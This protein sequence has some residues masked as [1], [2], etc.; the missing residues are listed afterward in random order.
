[1]V[2]KITRMPEALIAEIQA[3]ADRK[4][5]EGETPNFAAAVRK[6]CRIGLAVD[7]MKRDADASD[8]D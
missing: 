5:P 3:Y 6:L 7:E 1:M 4:A 2:A 8:S